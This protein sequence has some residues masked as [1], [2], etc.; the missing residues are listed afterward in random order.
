[1][2]IADNSTI[3]AAG[4]IEPAAAAGRRALEIGL[5]TRSARILHSVRQLSGMI[6]P[7]STRSGVAEFCDAFT[8]W[9]TEGCP[10]RT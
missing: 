5:G 2:P 9:E 8:A 1:M 10:D 7:A 4:E 3:M 6:D